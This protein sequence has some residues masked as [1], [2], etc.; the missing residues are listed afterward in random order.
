DALQREPHGLVERQHV[1]VFVERDG[2]EERA[3][4]I[5]DVGVAPARTRLIQSQWRDAHRLPGLESLLGLRALAVHAQFALSNDALDVGEGEP[6]E[7]RLDETS[8][9]PAGF[10]RCFPCGLCA[11]RGGGAVRAARAAP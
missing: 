7:P 3:G 6:P 5:A 8:D 10:F 11:G 2:L 1:G 4:L 9:A